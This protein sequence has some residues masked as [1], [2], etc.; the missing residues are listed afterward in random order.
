MVQIVPDLTAEVKQLLGYGLFVI[1][2][3]GTVLLFDGCESVMFPWEVSLLKIPVPSE[4]LIFWET[5]FAVGSTNQHCSFVLTP[6]GQQWMCVHPLHFGSILLGDAVVFRGL[7]VLFGSCTLPFVRLTIIWSGP[8]FLAETFAVLG[9]VK[10]EGMG[11]SCLFVELGVP[12]SSSTKV[13]T[14]STYLIVLFITCFL[15]SFMDFRRSARWFLC[16][17]VRS[18]LMQYRAGLR[19]FFARIAR[20]SDVVGS[21]IKRSL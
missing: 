6:S 15:Y 2:F 4:H 11:S 16:I 21:V 20:A 10:L 1:I 18:G 14:L 9:F 7:V 12:D 8:P 3:V 13:G 19:F 5:K 17:S